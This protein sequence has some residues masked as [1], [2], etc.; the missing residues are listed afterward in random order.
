MSGQLF[1]RL[2]RIVAFAR[3][4]PNPFIQRKNLAVGILYYKNPQVDGGIEFLAEVKAG[5]LL[6]EKNLKLPGGN[7]D[8]KDKSWRDAFLREFREETGEILPNDSLQELR[9]VRSTYISRRGRK[10]QIR[11]VAFATQVLEKRTF[12]PTIGEDI[13]GYEWVTPGEF[14][15]RA[16]RDTY[17]NAIDQWIEEIQQQE[18]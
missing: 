12:Q 9:E 2:E 18:R 4:I 3:E 16:K 6:G 5:V 17:R 1:F 10:G 7:V 15:K 13:A 14:K 8:R 11:V